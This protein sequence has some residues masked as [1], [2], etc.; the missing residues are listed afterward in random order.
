MIY[1]YILKSQKTGKYYVGQTNDLDKRLSYH[2]SGYNKST[3]GG[4]PWSLVYKLPCQSREEA[5]R[6]EN[7]I[8]KKKSKKYIDRLIDIG[9]RPD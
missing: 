2:N 8:K 7:H 5:V 4:S 3:R 6:L 1:L 9:E